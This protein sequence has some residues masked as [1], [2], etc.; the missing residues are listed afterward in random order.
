[1]RSEGSLLPCCGTER[2]WALASHFTFLRSFPRSCELTPRPSDTSLPSVLTLSLLPRAPLLSGFA[3]G[4]PQHKV[5]TRLG[6]PDRCEF[7]INNKYIL[8]FPSQVAWGTLTL[9]FPGASADKESACSAGDQGLIPGLGRSPEKKAA[10]HSSILTWRILWTT[11][12]GV[13]KSRT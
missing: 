4:L 5:S 2:A 8:A 3:V 9:D 13:T 12:H 10:T 11:I 6:L 7:Q 1:M